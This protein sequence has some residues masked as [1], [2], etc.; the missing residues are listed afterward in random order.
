MGSYKYR[1]ALLTMLF[2]SMAG[3]AASFKP[4]V[5]DISYQHDRF[6]TQP[7][8]LPLSFGAYFSSFDSGDDDNGDGEADFWRIPHFVSYEMRKTDSPL[9]KGP[10]RPNPWIHSKIHTNSNVYPRGYCQVN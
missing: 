2:V 8:D 3:F 10:G 9:G 7:K 4:I 5:L 1:F 6:N